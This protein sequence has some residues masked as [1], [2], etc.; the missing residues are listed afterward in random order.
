M[1][2]RLK[3]AV[4]ALVAAGTGAVLLSSAALTTTPASAAPNGTTNYRL[5]VVGSDTIYCVDGGS[6]APNHTF[7]GIL[8]RYN[9]AVAGSTGNQAINTAP[10]ASINLGC[11]T[12]PATTSVPAD[13]F[14]KILKY[15][16]TGS[17][18]AAPLNGVAQPWLYPF[19]SSAGITCYVDDQGHGNIAFTRSSRGPKTTDPNNLEFWAFALDAVTWTHMSSNTHAP[20]SMTP[21]QLTAVYNCVDTK[22]GQ[23]TGKADTTPIKLYYPQVGSGTGDFFAQ[24]YLGGSGNRPGS[25][26]GSLAACDATIKFVPENDA[27]QIAAADQ[28]SAI[29]PYSFAVR[30]AQASTLHLEANLG[31]GTIMG[32]VNSVLPSVNSIKEGAAATNEN[33]SLNACTAPPVAGEFCGT[34][35]V[36]HTVWSS[37]TAPPGGF[38][39]GTLEY[40]ASIDVMGV[41]ASGVSGSNSVCSNKDSTVI[42]DYGF[43]PLTLATT[44]SGDGRGTTILAAGSKSYCR[45]Y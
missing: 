3:R 30:A 12:T 44:A 31:A 45:E 13:A 23:V 37:L 42:R 32:D 15:T 16:G 10:K 38:G 4:A 36:Y 41:P 28:S 33:P 34:R 8:G 7:T 2:H 11:K 18:C 25:R 5:N 17:A 27:T 19:G 26:T 20:V 40:N 22:W 24:V 14:H 21:A 29:L 1:S 43:R 35:Y 39:L 9:A 6:S